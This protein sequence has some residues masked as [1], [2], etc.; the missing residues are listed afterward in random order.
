VTSFYAFKVRVLTSRIGR[1]LWSASR[2]LTQPHRVRKNAMDLVRDE[3]PGKSFVDIGCMWRVEGEYCV[4][5]A[6]SGARSVIGVD[7]TEATEGFE[8]KRQGLPT[9]IEFIHGDGVSPDVMRR[10]GPVDVVL[11]SGVI[12]HHPSPYHLLVSL[13]ELCRETLILSSAT[14]PESRILGQAAIYYPGLPEKDRRL[15]DVAR[16]HGGGPRWA[17]NRPYDASVGYSNWYWGLTPS[18]LAAMVETAGF[19]V[20]AVH[21]VHPF[22]TVFLC[23]TTAKVPGELRSS[24]YVG[25][26]DAEAEGVRS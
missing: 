20:E 19:R 6:K 9:P 22:A 24:A 25:P 26:E 13:R 21:T 11:C 12:Y 8:R 17:I 16:S 7:V 3:V 23:R 2:R 14:I 1:R 18:C 10:I 5:A 15:W 4:T